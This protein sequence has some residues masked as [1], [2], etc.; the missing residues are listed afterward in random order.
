MSRGFQVSN[1]FLDLL[2]RMVSQP[3]SFSS[4]IKSG[5][6][7]QKLSGQK[8]NLSTCTATTSWTLPEKLCPIPQKVQ[9]FKS[10]NKPGS[11]LKRQLKD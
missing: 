9:N 2:P 8:K 5:S 11:S 7:P 10:F 6:F 4:N 1:S 3:Y